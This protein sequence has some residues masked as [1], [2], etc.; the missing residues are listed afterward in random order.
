MLMGDKPVKHVPVPP[1]PYGNP[2]CFGFMLRLFLVRAKM[3]SNQQKQRS[4]REQ[5]HRVQQT[6]RYPLP[7][8]GPL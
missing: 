7:S 8:I 6:V 1:S 5:G 4:S 3:G 2:T